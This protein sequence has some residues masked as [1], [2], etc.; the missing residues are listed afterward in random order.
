MPSL[1][2]AT[3]F[4]QVSYASRFLDVQYLNGIDL[5]SSPLILSS[6]FNYNRSEVAWTGLLGNNWRA[7]PYAEAGAARL[8]YTDQP[9]PALVNRSASDYH[10]K[11]GVR[12]TISPTLSSDVGWRVTGA[13]QTITG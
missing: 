10:A 11:A 4:L 13:I 9:A 5:P 6:A 12:L 2:I 3:V 8:D 1:A 7:A